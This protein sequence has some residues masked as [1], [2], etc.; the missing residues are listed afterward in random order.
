MAGTIGDAFVNVHLDPKGV[1]EQLSGLGGGLEGKFG[2]AGGAAG[3]AM[4]LGIVGAVAGTALMVGKELYAIGERFDAL[5]DDMQ[6][7][8]G[9][10]GK[11]LDGLVGSAK[12]VATQ[13]PASFEDAGKAVGELRSR[14]GLTGKALEGMSKQV[15]ELSRLTGD[16]LSSTIENSTRMFG[17]WGLSGADAAKGLDKVFRASQATGVPVGKLETLLTKFGGPMRQ[18]GFG[19][20]ETAALLGKFE[21][22]GVNTELVMGSMRIALG[23]FAREAQMVPAYQGKVAEAQDKL[24]KA[25]AKGEGVDVA[26]ENL[27]KFAEKLRFAKEAAKGAPKAVRA[28]FEEIRKAKTPTEGTAIALQAFGARA[29][30]DMAAAIR[31]GRFSI[32]DLVKTIGKGKGTIIDTGKDTA[33]FAEQW[34]MLKNKVFVALEPIATKLFNAI[35]DGMAFAMKELPPLVNALKRDLA[36]TLEDIGSIVETLMPVFREVFGFL[37]TTVRNLADELEGA[38]KVIGGAIQIV[39]S[40]LKGDWSGAWDG[41]KK[42]VE[43]FVQIITAQLNQIANV[44]NLVLTPIKAAAAAIGHAIVDGITGVVDDIGDKVR[45]AI[46]KGVT[47][48]EELLGG[49]GNRAAAIGRA[50]LTAIVEPLGDVGD[51]V[52]GAINKAITFGEELLGG[53]A[54]RAAA[55]GSRMLAAVVGALGDIGERVRGKINEAITFGEELLGAIA[56]R[57]IAIGS[58]IIS[59]VVGALTGLGSQVVAGLRR[60]IKFGK[61][62]LATIAS[63]AGKIGEGIADAV[64]DGIGNLGSRILSAL[65]DALDWALDQFRKV[66]GGGFVLSHTPG[67]NAAP[68]PPGGTAPGAL[69][70]PT[71]LAGSTPGAGVAGPVAPFQELRRA[72]ARVDTARASIGAGAAAA[73]PVLVRV[74]IGDQELRGIVRTEVGY[75]DDETAR[76]ALGGLVGMAG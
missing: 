65:K 22:E 56:G 37:V 29:G 13:V 18:L 61:D 9:A 32:D 60:E 54:G 10:T 39:S 40:L 2:K 44:L 11:E 57:A 72:L 23:K 21:K 30:P 24:T 28:T 63:R 3:M 34:M 16:D 14:T 55:I 50:L 1:E 17:D 51:K 47:F 64:V 70:A 31:E 74:F 20:D 75:A 52:R 68:A 35:G 25:L 43:G 6:V 7:A 5:S 48:G 62:L 67:F 42:V 66:P 33:D 49:L 58:R 41:A 59:A 45:G 27:A 8:T 69:A 71:A 38:F 36:P 73:A 15:L 12:R 26:Q 4:K 46:N 76:I 53:L 19:F